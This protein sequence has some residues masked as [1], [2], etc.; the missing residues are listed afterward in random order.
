MCMVVYTP[1]NL[2][3][4]VCAHTAITLCLYSGYLDVLNTADY[5]VINFTNILSIC[6]L[7]IQR[8]IFL[9]PHTMDIMS[10]IA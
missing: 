5:E 3:M 4:E 1:D 8:Q 9:I 2:V 7:V 6:A 10:E